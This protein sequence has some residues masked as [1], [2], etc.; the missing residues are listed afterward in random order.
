VPESNPN[1]DPTVATNEAVARAMTSERDYVDGQISVL[2]ERLNGI[3]RATELRWPAVEGVPGLIDEKISNLA[4]LMEEK[5]SSIE[6]QF[7]E[8]DTRQERES[9]DNKVAVDAAFAAQKEAAAKQDEANA[10]AIDKSERATA[11]TIKTNSELGRTTNDALVGQIGDLKERVSRIESQKAG[12]VEHRTEARQS[13]AAVYGALAAV[14]TLL[15]IIIVL[16]N[17]VTSQ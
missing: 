16:T 13:N 2:I 5:F 7:A 4:K 1:P 12:Y 6:T 11:E 15:G 10:K 8:R 17:V 9:R 14:A 3:D